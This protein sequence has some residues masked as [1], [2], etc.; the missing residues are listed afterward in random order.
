MKKSI[1]A[2]ALTSL[3]IGATLFSCKT[4]SE[5]EDDATKNVTEAFKDLTVNN[6]K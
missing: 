4:N 3:V 5:K 1:Q 6:K 2:I